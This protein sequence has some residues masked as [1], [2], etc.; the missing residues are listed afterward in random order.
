MTAGEDMWAAN[1][2]FQIPVAKMNA[3]IFKTFLL[4]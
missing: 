3:F 2:L 4:L 1:D